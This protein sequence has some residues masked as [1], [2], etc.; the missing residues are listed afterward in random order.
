MVPTGIYLIVARQPLEH[1]AEFGNKAVRRDPSAHPSSQSQRYS[2][3]DISGL[4]N[5]WRNSVRFGNW[6]DGGGSR[7]A[8]LIGGWMEEHGDAAAVDLPS[9]FRYFTF[10]AFEKTWMEWCFRYFTFSAFGKKKNDVG[11]HEPPR[12]RGKIMKLCVTELNAAATSTNNIPQDSSALM[13][14]TETAVY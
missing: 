5:R 14:M 10:S 4:V 6:T 3:E 11:M 9:R 2:L 13:V 8:V 12:S 1:L 7:L